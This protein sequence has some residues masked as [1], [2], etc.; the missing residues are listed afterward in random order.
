VAVVEGGGVVVEKHKMLHLRSRAREVEEAENEEE[1]VAEGEV[2]VKG[3]GVKDV[4]DK[5]TLLVQRPAVDKM[6]AVKRVR[7]PHRRQA[8]A[9]AICGLEG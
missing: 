9:Q 7:H 3:E 6:L 5:M 8:S 2:A 1:G 4:E